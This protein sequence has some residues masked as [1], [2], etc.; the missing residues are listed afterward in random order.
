MAGHVG[1]A[2]VQVVDVTGGSLPG[3][4]GQPLWTLLTETRFGA[5][6]LARAVLLVAL[7]L[8]GWVVARGDRIIPPRR[9]LTAGA[10]WALALL[11][12]AAA[13]AHDQPRQPRRRG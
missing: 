4:L 10:L 3:V 5:L 7:G 1:S 11:S 13:P 9:R 6:W 12:R 2:V 8:L